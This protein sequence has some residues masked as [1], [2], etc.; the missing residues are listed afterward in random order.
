ME[1]HSDCYLSF[2]PV[3]MVWGDGE[4][5]RRV[6][7]QHKNHHHVFSVEEIITGGGDFCPSNSRM[8]KNE[9]VATPE[10]L[11]HVPTGDYYSQIMSAM[12][13][14]A[15]YIPEIMSVYN[16]KVAGSWSERYRSFVHRC[17]HSLHMCE[18]NRLFNQKTG[19]RYHSVF[20]QREKYIL[21]KHS[22]FKTYKHDRETLR[23]IKSLVWQNTKGMFKIKCALYICFSFIY[24]KLKFSTL[25][26]IKNR[27]T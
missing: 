13:G 14:G 23:K 20:K 10:W 17:E 7:Q 16:K 25:F 9:A 4:N 27:V 2:H 11:V 22:L 12:N 1:K 3:M 24:Y 5:S 15:L 18:A 26:R 19:Y 8:E 21:K 6:Y